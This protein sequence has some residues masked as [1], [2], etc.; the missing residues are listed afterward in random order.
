MEYRNQREGRGERKY[1]IQIKRKYDIKVTHLSKISH[2]GE[3]SRAIIA[4]LTMYVS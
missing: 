1:T 2:K 4:D 3:E